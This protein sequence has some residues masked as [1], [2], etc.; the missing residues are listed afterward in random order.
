[1]PVRNF[2]AWTAAHGKSQ[3]LQLAALKDSTIG[4]EASHYLNKL[5]SSSPTKEPLVLALGGFP[6][7]LRSA[8]END[9]QE[10]KRLGIKP[11]FM[12]NGCK[13]VHTEEPFSLKDDGPAGR[14]RAWEL[15]EKGLAVEAVEAFGNAGHTR[16]AEVYNV[17]KK[18]L[19]ENKI[20]FQVAPYAAWPQLVYLEKK[21]FVDAIYGNSELFF[22]D[23]EKVIV[24]LNIGR[25]IF[26]WI[27]KHK[28]L[29]EL[30]LSNDQFIDVL[31][32][33]GS[34]IL[35]SFPPLEAGINPS[36]Q[37]FV[38]SVDLI[39]RLRSVGNVVGTTNPDPSQHAAYLEKYK[40]ARASVK[41][42][43]IFTDKGKAEQLEFSD[44]PS[45]VHEFIGQRLPEELYFYLSRG[46]I[47]SEVLDMLATG[48]LIEIAPLDNGE[49]EEYRKFLDV[50][51]G[52]R[53]QALSLLAQSL[54]RWWL[55]KEVNVYYWFD[56][57]NPKKLVHK[58]V[59]PKPYEL[60]KKW[61]VKEAVF[62]P[63]VEKTI[64]RVAGLT[65]AI[66][67]LVI[68]SFA[69]KTIV[70]KDE[71]ADEII[72][73]TLWRM[74]QLRNF[75]D[76]GKHTLT[77]WGRGL[78]AALSTLD[79]S[80]NIEESI[81]L[82]FELMRLKVLKSDNFASGEASRDEDRAH[83]MLISQVASLV[84]INHKS[85]GYTGP[86]NRSL[87]GFNSF[88]RGLTRT[89]RNFAE[90]TLAS[91][92]MH[93]DAD[94][95]ERQDWSDLGLRLPFIDEVNAGLGIAVK[96]YLDELSSDVGPDFAAQKEIQKKNM[97][98]MFAQAADVVDDLGLAFKVWDAIIVGIKTLR[99]AGEFVNESKAF[100]AAD[101]WLA[102]RR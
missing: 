42:H 68:P 46:V 50:L 57:K 38:N 27:N 51:N 73:N 47:G 100:L 84:P 82:A 63:E 71:D 56:K 12:F 26:T 4:I 102:K 3:S 11:I 98:M 65:F 10:L 99:E 25:G 30:N 89:L 5:L 66:T 72:I 55:S 78:Q 18:I 83:T 77:P 92:L 94:R 16:P 32:L 7:S 64:D 45:D 36:P 14:G 33:S 35:R 39:R 49:S 19:R 31:M 101:E 81:Y 69:E 60:T 8:V 95:D 93:G 41:H 59:M 28:L 29:A 58:D 21:N 9:L 91:L 2:D 53:T 48:Q 87:L 80:V 88:V 6:F 22:F 20:D 75:I 74:L 40:R 13:L 67:S 79:V 86:L 54:H 97:P 15:Y 85:I 17:F 76:G 24:D 61:N 44:S 43:V 34:E 70:P 23:V 96:T 52:I 90:M 62:R 37:G 1:M